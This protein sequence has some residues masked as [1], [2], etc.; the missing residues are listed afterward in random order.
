MITE[1]A[2]SEAARNLKI[3]HSGLLRELDHRQKQILTLFSESKYV[4]TR[5]ITEL[6]NIHPRT[7][8]NLCKKWIESDFI[9]QIG[10]AKKSR[11]YEL[12]DQ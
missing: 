3:D 8:L 2:H 10:D 11:K 4:S 9:I 7:A 1:G 5:E 6:L 12:A